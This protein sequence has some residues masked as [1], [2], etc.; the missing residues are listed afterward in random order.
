MT[1]A[2]WLAATDSERQKW[3][4]RQTD[5]RKHHLYALACLPAIAHYVRDTRLV[6]AITTLAEHVEERSSAVALYEAWEAASD[7]QSE[8][9]SD[10]SEQRWYHITLAASYAVTA[11]AESEPILVAQ[12]A[13]HCREV[14]RLA[15]GSEAMRTEAAAQADL[16]RCIFAN[17]FRPVAFDPRWRSETA[18]A[19]AAA[20][21]EART[22]DR[23]PI[24]ADALEEAGCDH[25]D[26]LAHCR[27]PGP[28]A[29]GCWAVDLVLGKG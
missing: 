6:A 13:G 22:F 20:I 16:L 18:V 25:A 12:T 7:A 8:M 23:M 3:L 14:L 11:A 9:L 1:E 2:E 10:P 27:G 24:L 5:L 28:H 15:N 4:N 17:P 21:Y 19:L 26:L 29:R